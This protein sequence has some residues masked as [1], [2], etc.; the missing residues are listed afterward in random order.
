MSKIF[1]L[2]QSALVDNLTSLD[3]PYASDLHNYLYNE[4]E[5]FIYTADAEVATDTMG[6]WECI[7]AVQKYEKGQ[8]GEVYTPLSDAVSVANMVVYILGDAL[9]YEIFSDTIYFDDKWNEQLSDDDLAAMLALAKKWFDEN[10]NGL[11]EIWEKL[12]IA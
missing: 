11:Q 8:F 5:H 12:D 4:T 10:P 7:G 1:A 2:V 9:L 3:R 6:V